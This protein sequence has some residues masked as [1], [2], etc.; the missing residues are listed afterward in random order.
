MKITPIITSNEGIAQKYQSVYMLADE[1]YAGTGS[2]CNGLEDL[3]C[4]K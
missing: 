3:I 1:A 4:I 2:P